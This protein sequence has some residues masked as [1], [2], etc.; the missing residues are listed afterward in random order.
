MKTSKLT[1]LVVAGA[2]TLGSVSVAFADSG[3]GP[4][5]LAIGMNAEANL[6]TVLAALVVKGTI[7]QAQSDAIVAALKASMP[8]PPATNPLPKID[9]EANK[10]AVDAIVLKTLG[11]TAAALKAARAAGK[12]LAQIDPTKTT[13]LIAALVAYETTQ[14]DA[15][16]TAAKIT[17]AQAVTLKAGLTAAV[18]ARVNDTKGS[19]MGMGGMGLGDGDNDHAGR[20]PGAG[21]KMTP[22]PG[23]SPAPSIKA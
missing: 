14:I 17:A 13:A 8:T 4:K 21:N 15:A 16:V 6:T 3:K 1:A 22:K 5:A 10:A 12:S 7:T 18:T 20:G 2:L 19:G 23:A 9:L 11:I